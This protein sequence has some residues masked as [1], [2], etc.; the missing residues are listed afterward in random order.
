M[1]KVKEYRGHIRNWKV[2]CGELGIAQSLSREARE[3][4][5]LIK[6]YEAWGYDMADH[7]HGMFAFAL[8]DEDEQK[9]FCLIRLARSRFIIMKQRKVICF[10]ARP[11]VRLWTSRDL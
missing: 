7:M 5:I 11:F 6:A 3:E 2:L 9:L 10:T 8:W 4:Q 1:I